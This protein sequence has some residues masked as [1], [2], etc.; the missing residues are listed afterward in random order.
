MKIYMR[1]TEDEYELPIAVADSQTELAQ[2]VG[3]SRNSIASA[4][5]HQRAGSTKHSVYKEVEV[6]DD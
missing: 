6:E 2:M 4:L 1:V 5:C 3:V